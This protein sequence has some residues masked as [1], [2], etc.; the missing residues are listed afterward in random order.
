M[1]IYILIYSSVSIGLRVGFAYTALTEH[2]TW[3]SLY[4][5]C[6]LHSS[7]YTNVLI[8]LVLQPDAYSS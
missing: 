8:A 2:D 7:T 1:A 3:F 5:V 4:I 6:D